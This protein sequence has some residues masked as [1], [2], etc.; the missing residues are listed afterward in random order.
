MGA[1]QI[2]GRQTGLAG[3]RSPNFNS[4]EKGPRSGHLSPIGRTATPDE[5]S[6]RSGWGKSN[7][8]FLK[9]T[10]TSDRGDPRRL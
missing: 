5:F 9:D 1:Y 3:A 2:H 8:A 6:N 7:C 4:L 10:R